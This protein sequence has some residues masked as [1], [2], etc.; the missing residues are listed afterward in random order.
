METLKKA[1]L[2]AK[3]KKKELAKKNKKKKGKKGKFKIDENTSKQLIKKSMAKAIE[4]EKKKHEKQTRDRVE[5]IAKMISKEIDHHQPL[6]SSTTTSTNSKDNNNNNKPFVYTLDINDYPTNVR[7]TITY[8]GTL[9]PLREN[10]NVRIIQKG[11]FVTNIRAKQKD[12]EIL[13]LHL[14]ISGVNES[15]VLGAIKELKQ[16]L[17]QESSKTN[18]SH[19]KYA[20]YSVV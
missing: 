1:L 10:Y 11:Q 5:S 16:I 19:N 12:N 13:P 3:K 17:Y 7:K 2:A 20:K 6:L 8:K 4:K 14:E 9:N 15:D 18:Y